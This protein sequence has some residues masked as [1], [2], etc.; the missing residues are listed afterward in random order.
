MAYWSAVLVAVVLLYRP[1]SPRSH[2]GGESKVPVII[3]RKLFHAVAVVMLVPSLWVGCVVAM[4]ATY[5]VSLLSH[6]CQIA[7]RLLAIHSFLRSQRLWRWQSLQ[8]VPIVLFG[9]THCTESKLLRI[10]DC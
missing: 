7:F 3:L 5:S 2:G 6:I 1:T 4:H 8:Y 10:L 9:Q